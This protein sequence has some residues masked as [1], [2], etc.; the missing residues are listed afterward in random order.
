MDERFDTNV[1]RVERRDEVEEILRPRF[2]QRSTAEW[3]G[4]FSSRGVLFAP[5]NTFSEILEHEQSK[6]M[7]FVTEVDHPVAGKLRQVAPVIRMSETPGGIRT[8]P[9][10]LGQ[11]TVEILT[12]LGL[13]DEEVKSLLADGAVIANNKDN[14]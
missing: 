9:P 1:K 7:E 2:G 13:D 14:A 4:R 8:A 11:H 6:A 5:V 3:E 10:L 12:E